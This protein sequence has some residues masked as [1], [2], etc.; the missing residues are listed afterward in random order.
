MAFAF[1]RSLGFLFRCPVLV[2][3]ALCLTGCRH[4]VARR[5]PAPAPIQFRDVTAEAGL[6]F[7]HTTGASGRF[8][9][10]ETMGSG[11]AFFDYDRDGRPDIFLVN[12]TYLPGAHPS[13][14][15]PTQAL[16]H[17]RGDGT[18]EEVSKKAG[19]AVEMYGMGCAAADYDN[20]DYPDLYVSALGPDRLFHNNRDGTF[21]DV[22]RRAG[23]DAPEWNTS[24]A[25]LDGDRDGW[26]DLYVCGYS[27]WTPALNRRCPDVNG[28]PHMCTPEQYQ[29]VS[30]RLFRNRHNGTF[31]DVTQAAGVYQPAGKSLAALEWDEND[32]GWPDIVVANDLEPNLLYR[33]Q[34]NGRFREVGA[35][36][37]L[38]FSMAGKARAGMGLDSSDLAGSGREALLVGNF[39]AEGLGLY[40]S[41][42]KGQFTDVADSSGLVPASLTSLTFGVLFCD[43]DLDGRPDIL[44][45]NGHIDPNVGLTGSGVTY[46]ERPRL[47]RQEEDDRFRDVT[48]EA[49]P[50]LQRPGVYR[51]IAVADIN[52]DGRPDVLLSANEGPPLLLKN[53]S[54]LGSHWLELRLQGVRSNRDGIGARVRLT[55]GDS[56]AV[57][58][59]RWIRAGSGYCSSSEPTAFF[60]L[61]AAS[62]ARRVEIRWPTGAVQTL[63]HVHADR[64]LRVREQQN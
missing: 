59:T 35:E 12:S 4:E 36:A 50:G 40:Q 31:A 28:H 24:V 57:L 10:P 6:R 17:N 8:Y 54:P 23:I 29:G 39:S 30:S 20:D 5:P 42:G 13:G 56:P 43:F 33:N 61:G 16:Y 32:D 55:T 25:W 47:F 64:M 45:A 22:T 48:A 26:L 1:L 15:R 41:D 18:F 44:T 9:F 63:E 51:G 49:G 11:C 58:Q 14:P 27:R 37:G 52:G 53:E 7:H 38:A 21:S 34:K 46:R 2:P 62:E 3:L 19:L 60:G